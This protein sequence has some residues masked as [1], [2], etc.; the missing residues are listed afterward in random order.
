MIIGFAS[1]GCSV[2][3]Y[4]DGSSD[5]EMKKFHATKDGLGDELAKLKFVN[6]AYQ[7]RIKEKE[8]EITR[9]NMQNTV[10]NKEIED[11]KGQIQGLKGQAKDEIASMGME[12][13]SFLSGQ[14]GRREKDQAAEK[15][16][17]D[18]LAELEKD[19]I[20]AYKEEAMKITKDELWQ[21][22]NYF[23]FLNQTYQKT[24]EHKENELAQCNSQQAPLNQKVETL[25]VQFEQLKSRKD[26]AARMAKERK[27]P[28][29][30][31]SF[32]QE[33]SRV[34]VQ[35]KPGET[36]RTGP[37]TT[38]KEATPKTPGEKTAIVTKPSALKSLQIKVLSG[39]GK[40]PSAKRMAQ[41]LIQ[42]GYKVEAIDLA[43][44]SNIKKNTVFYSEDCRQEAGHISKQL[45]GN[46]II[47]PLS[48]PSVF[49]LIIVTG[50]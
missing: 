10:L 45:G 11:L 6:Q 34:A 7:Q 8:N 26:E 13:S 3:K 37:E 49:N 1:A 4:L 28:M 23:K 33:M 12:E 36:A 22:V 2:V 29:A 46:T 31:P 24:V 19:Q 43:P 21:Q 40:L 47:K 15:H 50:N 44:R 39:D 30:E 9:C 18:E 38:I 32:R 48:W 14:P 20:S 25:R 41:K 5:E 17:H 16:R 42:M 27:S 35:G